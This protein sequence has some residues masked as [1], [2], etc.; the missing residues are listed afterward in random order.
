MKSLFNFLVLRQRLFQDG[1]LLFIRLLIGW[2]L[3]LTGKGKLAHLDKIT[4]F[5]AS[6]NI[7][8]PGAHAVLIGCVE[9]FGG[10]AL[11]IGLGARGFSLLITGA[12]LG[13][14]LTAHRDEAFASVGDFIEAAPFPYLV[15]ALVVLV[16]GPGRAS[17][18]QLIAP[19][20]AKRI[21]LFHDAAEGL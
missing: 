5:F 2:Q 16:F 21:P 9:M 14:Y 6:L 3:F 8:A 17:L 18:D 20:L 11:L 1:V 15:V 7:P 13:A 12:M 19:R 10:L 4:E